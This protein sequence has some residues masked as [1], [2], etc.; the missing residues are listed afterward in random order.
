VTEVVFD[1]ASR[2]AT[3]AL[4]RRLAPLLA[5]SDLVILSGDLG[6][7]K[8][9]FARALCRALGVPHDIDITSP[10]FTL[11]HELAGRLPILHADAYRLNHPA[12]VV[13]LGLRDARGAG[14]LLIVE[15]GEPYLDVLGGEAIV[16]RFEHAGV[17]GGLASPGQTLRRATLTSAG[18]RGEQIV[19]R[20]QA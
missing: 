12:E 6:A 13:S 5:A 8:T 1:L 17:P 4:A 2:R 16:L 10:T 11:V 14:A 7:G 15:W 9:F 18:L 19:L 3:V 20:V